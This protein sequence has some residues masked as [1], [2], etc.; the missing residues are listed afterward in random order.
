MRSKYKRFLIGAAILFTADQIMKTYAE[1][2][3]DIK[4]EKKLPGPVVLRKTRNHGMFLGVLSD[5]PALVRG[6]SAIVSGVVTALQAVS[7]M[8]KD[9]YRRKV[10][11]TFLSAGAWSNTF[12]RFVRG[13]LIDR[14]YRGYVVDYIGF[15]FK[16]PKLAKIT[17][18]LGDF[19]IAAG[20]L[21]M[22]VAGQK[23]AK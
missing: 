4:D 23:E 2:E 15:S 5:R 18:N 7:L 13:N 10:G 14:V 12:D 20:V 19:F 17:Y 1:Q 22:A 21:C 3:L 8:R 9:G 16:N 11:L 6:L